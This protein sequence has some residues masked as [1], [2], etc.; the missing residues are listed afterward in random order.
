MLILWEQFGVWELV[1]LQIPTDHAQ[2]WSL[3]LQVLTGNV[4]FPPGVSVLTKGTLKFKL[5]SS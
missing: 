2:D 1:N 3:V 5:V 4:V